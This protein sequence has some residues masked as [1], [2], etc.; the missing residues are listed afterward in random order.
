MT[1]LDR[2]DWRGQVRL[3]F[4]VAMTMFVITIGIGILNGLDLVDFSTAE[5]R[6]TVLTHVHSGTLGWITLAIL[7]ATIWLTGHGSRRLALAFAI[8]I[9]VYVAAFW[10]GSLPARAITGVILLGAVF[11]LA[12]WAWD[13]ARRAPSLPRVAVALGLTT[14][15]IGAT[16]G[17]LLQ[18]QLATGIRF[19]PTGGDSVGAHAAAMVF[20]YLV[21]VAMALLEWRLLGTTGRPRLGMVQV[22]GLVIGGLLLVVGLLFLDEAGQQPV[23]ALYLLLQL[24]AVILFAVRIVP[25]ALRTSWAAA[26][27][28]R[29]L[30]TSS[31]FV[32]V[33]MGLFMSFVFSA[34]TTPDAVPLGVL[35]ASDHATFIGVI[36]N[37]MFGLLV[38]FTGARRTGVADQLAYVLM[39]AGLIVFLVGLVGDSVELKRIGSPAMG[40]GILLG[41]ALFA[42]RL[43]SGDGPDEAPAAASARA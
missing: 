35:V 32:F 26:G 33:A 40:V 10:S 23:G 13:V 36:T 30:A 19:F 15:T 21:V 43:S 3:L 41:L 20:S 6:A 25:T 29:Y 39:N 14:F 38:A 28:G 42:S 5:L 24:I 7:A 1:T 9:P 2:A 37:L 4:A 11:V 27:E 34:I 12:W 31:L 18:V 8:G 17:V 22:A 16:L